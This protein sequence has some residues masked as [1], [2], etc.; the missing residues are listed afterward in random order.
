MDSLF[1]EPISPPSSPQSSPSSVI[2]IIDISPPSSPFA[3]TPIPSTELKCSEFTSKWFDDSSAMWRANK[4]YSKSKQMFRY[5]NDSDS[6]IT[7]QYF[8]KAENNRM[9]Q[10]PNLLNWCQCVYSNTKGKRCQ[11]KGIINIAD[12]MINKEYDY[13]KYSDVYL[14]S[15]HKRYMQK[16]QHKRELTI[17]CALIEL[18]IKLTNKLEKIDTLESLPK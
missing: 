18:H 7:R 14:C 10:Y 15:E 6:A 3:A 9:A 17:E 11:K 4:K 13:E 5:V 2:E 8:S 12:I 16:E 1:I